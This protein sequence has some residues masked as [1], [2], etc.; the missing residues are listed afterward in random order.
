MHSQQA[1]QAVQ[2]LSMLSNSFEFQR[3]NPPHPSMTQLGICTVVAVVVNLDHGPE[4]GLLAQGEDTPDFYWLH[5]LSF[6]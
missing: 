3:I 1:I 4:I 6:K 2:A 5:E